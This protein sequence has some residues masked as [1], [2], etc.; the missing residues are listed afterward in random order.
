MYHRPVPHHTFS[1]PSIETSLSTDSIFWGHHQFLFG[2]RIDKWDSVKVGAGAPPVRLPDGWLLIYHGVSSAT[3]KS[4]GGR[5]SADAV[6]LD[7]GNP[8][9]I[10]ARSRDPLL[11]PERDYEKHGFMP[12]VILPTGA[13][14]S[15]DEKNLLLF[16]GAA[17]ELVT[18]KTIPVQSILQHL[19][20]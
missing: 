2:P 9:H 14:L 18:L 19:E 4:P 10:L 15:E 13:L 11:S 1:T 5:Y 20:V 3:S 16:S 6:L 8:L 7:K 17:D 12:N